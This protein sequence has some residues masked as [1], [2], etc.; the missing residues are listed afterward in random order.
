[1]RATEIIRNLLDIIDH[2]EDQQQEQSAVVIAV[3]ADQ[4]QPVKYANEPHELVAPVTAAF[5]AGDDVHKSKNPADIRTNAPSMYP[6]FQA[7]Q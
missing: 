5:P 6:N 1:M 4:E 2:V 7:K 3:D